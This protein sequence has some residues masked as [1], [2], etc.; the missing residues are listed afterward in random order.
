VIEMQ[1]A[2]VLRQA[3]FVDILLADPE[4]VNAEFD[5]IVAAGLGTPPRFSRPVRP[6]RGPRDNPRRDTRPVHHPSVGDP[7]R[8]V[9]AR[10]RGPPG[11]GG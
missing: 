8:A 11:A 6:N 7:G 2:D 9:P 1:G 5:A 3:D 10:Q 4:W